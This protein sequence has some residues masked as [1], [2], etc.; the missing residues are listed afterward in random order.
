MRSEFLQA[1]ERLAVMGFNDADIDEI[2]TI[3][4]CLQECQYILEKKRLNIHWPS[5]MLDSIN[6][7]LSIGIS[8]AQLTQLK[9]LMCRFKPS[10]VIDDQ[11]WWA[12]KPQVRGPKLASRVSKRKDVVASQ[13]TLTAQVRPPTARLKRKVST[14]PA[15]QALSTGMLKRK[16]QS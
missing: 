15:T 11:Q 5:M 8:D 3:T 16:T 13:T 12:F 14:K 9:E 4:R 6:H 2:G 7:L 10:T 1:Y